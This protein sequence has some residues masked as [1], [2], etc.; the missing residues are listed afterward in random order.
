MKFSYICW[1]IILNANFLN[2]EFDSG[3]F[4]IGT[5]ISSLMQFLINNH[6]R[7]LGL[8]KLSL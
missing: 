4:M 7:W 1:E 6:M 5:G 2:F 8:N 3:Y